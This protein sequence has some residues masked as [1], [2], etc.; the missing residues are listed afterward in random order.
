MKALFI[1]SHCD[2]ELCFA[3]AMQRFDDPSYVALSSC[4]NKQLSNECYAAMDILGVTSVEIWKYPVR[5]FREYATEI[6]SLF[7]SHRPEMV[8]THSIKDRHPDHRT[9]GE[10][11]LRVF[12]CNLLTYIGPWN[13]DEQANYF[14]EL[15][16]EQLEKKIEALACYKSQAHRAYMNPEFIR[17]WARYNGIKC[18]KLYAEGFKVVRLVQ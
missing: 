5:G 18:G 8:I 17:S 4:G 13:G 12:N 2:D 3:G 1:A 14:I 16:K 11:S 7:A 9:T 10:E 6:A 15:T